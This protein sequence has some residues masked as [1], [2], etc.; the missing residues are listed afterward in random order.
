MYSNL[1]NIESVN[2]VKNNGVTVQRI[3]LTNNIID[4]IIN[5][6]NVIDA[7]KRMI[8]LPCKKKQLVTCC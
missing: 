5:K 6:E 4:I 1:F 2:I 7:T 3:K 8:I